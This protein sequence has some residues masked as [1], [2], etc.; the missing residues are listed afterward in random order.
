[1]RVGAREVGVSDP[2]RDESQRD[3][4]ELDLDLGLQADAERL[5]TLRELA[6]DRVVVGGLGVVVDERSRRE[7]L[8]VAG[9]RVRCGSALT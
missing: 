9:R 1:M 6:A 2:G 4:L 8:V 7:L 5:R 3:V